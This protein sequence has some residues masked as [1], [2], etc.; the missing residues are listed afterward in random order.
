MQPSQLVATYSKLPIE[1]LE[2][3]VKMFNVNNK[4]TRI[5]IDRR[6]KQNFSNVRKFFQNNAIK[7]FLKS[8]MLLIEVKIKQDFIKLV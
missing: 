2:Q 6:L 4:D 5:F 7:G 1:T 3:G 8:Y